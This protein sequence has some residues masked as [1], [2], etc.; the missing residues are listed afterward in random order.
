MPQAEEVLTVSFET[1]ATG[2]FREVSSHRAGI[3]DNVHVRLDQIADLLF[4]LKNSSDLPVPVAN[5]IGAIE[6]MVGD[7]AAML[8]VQS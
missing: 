7:T 2:I 6:M 1:P 3:V 4:L 8:A 5:A